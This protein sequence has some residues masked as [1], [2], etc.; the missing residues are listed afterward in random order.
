MPIYEFPPEAFVITGDCGN[1]LAYNGWN[2]YIDLFG[3]KITTK[4][5]TKLSSFAYFSN[6]LKS[7]PFD[8]NIASNCDSY[9][10]AFYGC[11]NLL[12]APRIVGQLPLP[13]STYSGF[14]DIG[15]L[16]SS[17]YR[18]REIPYDYF[19]TFGGIDYWT[20]DVITQSTR[21]TRNGLFQ[22]CYSLRALPDISMLKNNVAYYSNLYNS[23][24][25]DCCTL[26]EIRNLP[27]LDGTTYTSNLFSQSIQRCGRLKS[28]TFETNVDGSPKIAQWKSQTIEAY[29]EIGFGREAD[30][31]NYNSG[32]T[33]ETQIID[34]ATYQALKNHPDS[35][36]IILEYSRYNHNSAVET[37][38][39]LP[40]TSAYLASVG[41]TNTIKFKPTAGAK[42]DGGAINTLTEEE[43][44]VAAAKGWTVTF[45]T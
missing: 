8:L 19:Y 30:V 16:F 9:A 22:S 24:C 12:T 6:N 14:A 17:C 28:F 45:S 5:I 35:W 36:T 20:S 42:T 44:A 18:I 7:I 33:K 41:G 27:V 43:I 38:N 39:S 31:L 2:W 15:S 4:D 26:D 3:D 34:D 40:D 37:I 11:Y 10:N 23:L 1:K 32:L 13:T 29:Y 21:G 25:R